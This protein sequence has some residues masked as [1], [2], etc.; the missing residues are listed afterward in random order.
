MTRSTGRGPDDR[1][2]QG[3]MP[4][5]IEAQMRGDLGGRSHRD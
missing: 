1:W 4:P 5:E 2:L 3:Q